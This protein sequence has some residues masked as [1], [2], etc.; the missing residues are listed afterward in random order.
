MKQKNSKYPY[1]VIFKVW[2]YQTKVNIL[3][4]QGGKEIKIQGQSIP[5]IQDLSARLREEIQI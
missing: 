4:A 1:M 3:R 5:F 2:N